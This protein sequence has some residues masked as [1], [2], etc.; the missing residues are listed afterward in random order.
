MSRR[1]PATVIAYIGVWAVYLVAAAIASGADPRLLFIAL[2]VVPSLVALWMRVRAAW[3]GVTVL[4]GINLV[5][6]VAAGRPAWLVGVWIGLIALLLA[7]PS[8]RFFR[9]DPG[10]RP[11]RRLRR[12]LL[13][14]AGVY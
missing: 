9:G 14:G 13:W 1:P 7:P 10:A 8:R 3:I 2:V 5:W 12:V 4:Q 11:S 6:L